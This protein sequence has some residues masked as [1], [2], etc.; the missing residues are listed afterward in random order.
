V[1]PTSLPPGFTV[2]NAPA[3]PPG[4]TVND[5]GTKI[6]A[7]GIPLGEVSGV[8]EFGVRQ[9][10]FSLDGFNEGLANILGAPVDLVN[11]GLSFLG[12]GTEEPAGGS[13]QIKRGLQATRVISKEQPQTAA[14]RIAKRVGQ[15]VGAAAGAFIP[16]LGAA[17]RVSGAVRTAA[18][19]QATAST[20]TN[21]VRSV[22]ETIA[23]DPA[24]ATAIETALAASAGTVAGLAREV[25]DTETADIV[26]QMIGAFGPAASIGLVRMLGAKIATRL[27]P[28]S[29][30]G[31]QR[32]A[33]RVLD[34]TITNRELAEQNLRQTREIQERIPDFRPTFAQATGDPGLIVTERAIARSSA[35]QSGLD[36]ERRAA[37]Q[38]ALVEAFEGLTPQG[39][40][41]GT[42]VELATAR[43]NR[44]EI[45]LQ[46][47]V[48]RAEAAALEQI[49][50]TPSMTAEQANNVV[51][52]QL[53]EEEASW[54]RHVKGLYKLV[55]PEEA[56]KG[57]VTELQAA[58]KA[59]VGRRRK[60]EDP[61]NNPTQVAKIIAE[62]DE[63]ESFAEVVALRQRITD[64][65][66]LEGGRQPKNR[67]LISKLADLLDATDVQLKDMAVRAGADTNVRYEEANLAFR[68][69]AEVFR[70][71]TGG[72]L[73]RRRA[74]G[75][76]A[77]PES[78]TVETFF[79]SGKGATEAAQDFNR[80][81]AGNE[82]ART[83]VSTFTASRML[84]QST[85]NGTLTS[86]NMV[87][88][89]RRHADAIREFPEI[90]KNV[91]QLINA[92]RAV[93]TAQIN[94][95][96]FI[97][98]RDKAVAKML[99]G[100]DADKIVGRILN[101]Q[102]PQAQMAEAM[103]IVG[104]GE[105]QAGLRRAVWDHMAADIQKQGPDP[106]GTAIINPSR[107][108]TFL[109][110]NEKVLVYQFGQ[111]HFD[112]LK[113]IQEGAAISQR[114]AASPTPAGSDTAQ[115]QRVLFT[116]NQMLSRAYG[117]QRGVVSKR[118]VIGELA[119]RI[120]SRTVGKINQKA[121]QQILS[122]AMSDPD[123][124]EA[125][126]SFARQPTPARAQRLRAFM[127]NLGVAKL[128]QSSE[129]ETE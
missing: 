73:L 113:I 129:E 22:V 103:R 26:G 32:Q 47:R 7:F 110:T 101:S 69:G 70:A 81:F 34:E 66:A 1:A 59:I 6:S 62:F 19:T 43:L 13:A 14:E 21:I 61:A 90:Q 68:Q 121:A 40:G 5:P 127:V 128:G 120:I 2:D 96:R 27:P 71:G 94:K 114:S 108:K 45:G 63:V 8:A 77:I 97:A 109:D 125:L 82:P 99:L 24:K 92:Q 9:S 111:K 65:M 112:N 57:S 98:F 55:D 80:I 35:E 95:Q 42:A 85:V 126:I 122:E 76:L 33:G 41:A 49:S 119:A 20:A 79:R 50:Q 3:L 4:F 15:E 16:V 106:A 102:N 84:E 28:V 18:G 46:N 93:E 100:T 104:R 115:N 51:R 117:V 30:Q 88:W 53:A 29:R 74:R 10:G 78:S 67:R 23:R 72:D 54:G 56:V 105:G 37:N 116:L 124:A 75:E 36:V 87:K 60:A 39:G 107:M 17:G 44:I 38:S 91:T 64:D 118:F 12:L 83:A 31:L 52:T 25:S 86:K 58:S 123:M 89:A 11:A 48:N